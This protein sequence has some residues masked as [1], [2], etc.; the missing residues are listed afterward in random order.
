MSTENYKGYRF[1]HVRDRES[2]GKI[3]TYVEKG[4][5]SKTKHL[6]P[7]KNGSPPYVCIKEKAKPSTLSKARELA[8][9]WADMNSR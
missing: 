4:T 2:P 6:Y 7:G 5:N 1:R 8:H 3:K 9:G